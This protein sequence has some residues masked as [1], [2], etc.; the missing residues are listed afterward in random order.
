MP[1]L[2]NV[3]YEFPSANIP[4]VFPSITI[5]YQGDVSYMPQLNP[6]VYSS[7]AIADHKA[8]TLYI[9]GQYDGSL[10]LDMWCKNKEQRNDMYQEFYKA[11]NPN[12]PSRMNLSLNLTDYYNIK[13]N[14]DLTSFSKEDSE[15]S[16]QTREWRTRISVLVNCN[17]L[18]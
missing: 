9:V 12:F 5:T 6:S 13:C 17:A 15:V 16:S 2:E 4:L 1:T 10:Q 14:Y 18:L 8:D 7:G 11:F 3:N